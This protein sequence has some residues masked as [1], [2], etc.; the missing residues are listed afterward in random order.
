MSVITSYLYANKI[1]VQ[2]L[3]DD[4]AIKTRNRVVYNRTVEV[5]KGTDNTIEINFKNQDQKPANVSAYSITGYL[6]D[7]TYTGTGNVVSNISVTISNASIGTAS[8]T[9]TEDLLAEL[10]ENK[11]KLAF[12]GVK[13]G[14]TESPLYSD[15]NYNL[16]TEINVNKGIPPYNP[17]PTSTVLDLG[18]VADTVI[19][20]VSDWGT[21]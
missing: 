20:D 5:Y 3:D 21:I 1:M 19:D 16:Y 14:T 7:S 6:I 13:N 4:P 18:S 9:L 10:D 8:I 2:I 12:K 15:D 11:Y 17:V